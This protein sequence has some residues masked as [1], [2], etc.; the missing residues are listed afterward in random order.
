MV[1]GGGGCDDG[2]DGIIGRGGPEG[3]KRLWPQPLGPLGPPMVGGKG[4]C[5]DGIDG[6]IG[7]GGPGGA[8]RFWPQP[9]GPLA[10][11]GRGG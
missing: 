10:V 2:I 3:A 1:G 4:G 7:R 11:G 6:I 5:N 8:K 9:L